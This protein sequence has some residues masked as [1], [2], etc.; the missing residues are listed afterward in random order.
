M[1]DTIRI[2]IEIPNTGLEEDILR[3]GEWEDDSLFG[4]SLRNAL[5]HFTKESLD[6]NQNKVIHNN[7][8]CKFCLEH[9]KGDTLY[10][11]ESWDGGIEFNYIR[12]IQYCPICGRKL[13]EMEESIDVY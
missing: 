3:K 2:S 4:R 6:Q 5:M 7:C 12:D 10:E 1:N 13:P 8:E 11:K 9:E